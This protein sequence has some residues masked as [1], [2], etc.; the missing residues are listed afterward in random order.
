MDAPSGSER[1]RQIRS[2]TYPLLACSLVCRSWL[3]SSQRHLFRRVILALDRDDCKRLDQALLS[4]PHLSNYIR[5]LKVHLR[6]VTRFQSRTVAHRAI[7]QSVAAAVLRKL[8]RLQSIEVRNL[9]WW[10]MTPDLRQTL[11]WLLVLPSIRFLTLDITR[12][13]SQ[14]DFFSWQYQPPLTRKAQE[15]NDDGLKLE[16]IRLARLDLDL[17]HERNCR[18]YVDWFLGRRSRYEPH[19]QTLCVDNLRH[20]DAKALNRLL[21]T[22]GSSLKHLEFYVPSQYGRGGKPEFD[23][24]LESNSNIRFLRLT[25]IHNLGYD[26]MSR[27]SLEMIWLLRLLSNIDNSN[28]LEQIQLEMI[29]DCSYGGPCSASGGPGEV[30]CLAG[31]FQKLQKLDI[32]FFFITRER[33]DTFACSEIRQRMLDAYP[34]SVGRGV[35]VDVRGEWCLLDDYRELF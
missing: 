25:N 13:E 20:E 33:H 16:R 7:D 31:K 21:R 10:L 3:P 12:Y 35:S 2:N 8:S 34:L 29:L 5:E 23:I 1:R 24:K 27:K 22:I 14:I 4:S 11:R 26:V 9:D 19:I 32:K 17:A 28:K 30:D 18:A 6:G 15:E